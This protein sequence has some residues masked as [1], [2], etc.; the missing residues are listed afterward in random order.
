[1]ISPQARAGSV[2]DTHT[3]RWP[4][5]QTGPSA[6]LWIGSIVKAPCLKSTPE[7]V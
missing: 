7:A 1:V 5:E 2:L 4:G 6:P 3:A